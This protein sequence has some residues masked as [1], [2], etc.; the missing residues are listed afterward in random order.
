MTCHSMGRYPIFTNGLGTSSVSSPNLVPRP[1]QNSTTFICAYLRCVPAVLLRGADL[2]LLR[3]KGKADL[4]VR[5]CPI[6]SNCHRTS[7]IPTEGPV[8][9]RFRRIR[10]RYG[11]SPCDPV[12]ARI[13]G[14]GLNR[15]H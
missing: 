2:P 13:S 15:Y 1:P 7:S 9:C 6:A 5:L 4:P 11:T 8:P 10:Q 3:L 12:E 14:F